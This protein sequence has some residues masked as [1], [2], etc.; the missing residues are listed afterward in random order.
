MPE[1]IFWVIQGAIKMKR[2]KSKLKKLKKLKFGRIFAVLF[3]FTV[4]VAFIFSVKDYVGI[5]GSGTGEKEFKTTSSTDQNLKTIPPKSTPEAPVPQWTTQSMNTSQAS[6]TPVPSATAAGLPL[7]TL[8]KKEGTSLST[9]GNTNSGNVADTKVVSKKAP[10]NGFSVQVINYSSID[11]IAKTVG[12]IL[13]GYGYDVS[14]GNAASISNVNS[15]IIEKKEKNISNE[16]KDILGI[17]K[18]D[19]KID[20]DSRFDAVVIVGDGFN[21]DAVKKYMGN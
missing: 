19:V 7:D 8:T 18:I 17:S 15:T 20:P 16:L 11:G 1:I 12:E 21:K 10:K 6:F 13:E 4:L 3:G 9:T 2:K 5:F 14:T